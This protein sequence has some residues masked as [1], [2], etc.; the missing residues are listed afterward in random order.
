MTYQSFD[1]KK[2][3][4]PYLWEQANIQRDLIKK[5]KKT[6]INFNK[7]HT[8]KTINK[9]VI[10]EPNN[11]IQETDYNYP[12]GGEYL[13]S[14]FPEWAITSLRPFGYW[15]GENETVDLSLYTFSDGYFKFLLYKIGENQY[16]FQW[17]ASASLFN[18]EEDTDVIKVTA[19]YTFKPEQR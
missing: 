5:L 12:N 11:P 1:S 18:E 17:R 14:N 6:E 7:L 10:F 15:T 2:R 16:I 13:L 19:L 9:I 8:T 4:L 3:K